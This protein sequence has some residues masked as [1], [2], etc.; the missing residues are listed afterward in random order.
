[1]R[2]SRQA[3]EQRAQKRLRKRQKRRKAERT[4]EEQRMDEKAKSLGLPRID[5]EKIRSRSVMPSRAVPTLGRYY[6][7]YPFSCGACGKREVWTAAQQKWWHEE[8]GADWERIA[9]HCRE[10]RRKEQRRRAEARRV[11]LEGLQRK[12]EAGS[13]SAISPAGQL[14]SPP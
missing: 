8:V 4:E 13:P 3:K 14:D 5:R 10:C 6:L 2:S 11:H 12:K 1:M 9:I 7:D